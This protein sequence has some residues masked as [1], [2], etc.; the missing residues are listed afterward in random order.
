MGVFTSQS[1]SG[2]A[3]PHKSSSFICW[4]KSTC[5]F[6]YSGASGSSGFSLFRDPHF[7]CFKAFLT[8][9]GMLR[10]INSTASRGE[11]VTRPNPSS[12]L[13]NTRCFIMCWPQ[14]C[15][16]LARTWFPLGRLETGRFCGIGLGLQLR[17][18]HRASL[19][20]QA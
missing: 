1:R 13:S 5:A 3:V 14:S 16:P 2:C 15:N 17:I 9:G 6:Y 20:R 12:L 18:T 19:A 8:P 4:T 10:T 7:V 11:S